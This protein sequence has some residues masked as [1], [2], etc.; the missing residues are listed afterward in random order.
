MYVAPEII[1]VGTVRDL[2]LGQK[3]GQSLDASFPAGTPRGKLTF[4]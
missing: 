3:D 1:E 4:S 2:T